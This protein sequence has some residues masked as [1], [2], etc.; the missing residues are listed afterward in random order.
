MWLSHEAPL[1]CLQAPTPAEMQALVGP[2]GE[3]MMKA[4]SLTEG[5]RTDEYQ[6]LKAVAD[7]LQAL[8]WVLYAGKESGEEDRFSDC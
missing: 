7:S 8:T 1:H 5:K 3:A 4:G 2:V 6:H